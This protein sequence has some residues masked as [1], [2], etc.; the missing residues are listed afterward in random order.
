MG[1]KCIF[2]SLT[3]LCSIKLELMYN[4]HAGGLSRDLVSVLTYE[5]SVSEVV[6]F[7]R[8]VIKCLDC[9]PGCR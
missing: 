3:M 7:G 5:L 2:P 4:P 9:W 1:N 8:C 6:I